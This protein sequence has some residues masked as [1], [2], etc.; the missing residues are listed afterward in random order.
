MFFICSIQELAEVYMRKLTVLITLFLSWVAFDKNLFKS[1][2]APFALRTAGTSLIHDGER[3][4]QKS[5]IRYQRRSIVPEWM[6]KV[7]KKLRLKCNY[8]STKSRDVRSSDQRKIR[9]RINNA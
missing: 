4:S 5:I 3:R 9:R 1:Q 7:D 2:K 6:P 8:F